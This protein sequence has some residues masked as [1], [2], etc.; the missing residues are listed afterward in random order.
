[1]RAE[2]LEGT[3]RA[4]FFTHEKHWRIGGEQNQGSFDRELAESQVL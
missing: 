3:R 2:E 1:V 4:P